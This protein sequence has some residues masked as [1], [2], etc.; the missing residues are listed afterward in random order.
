M[1]TYYI[2]LQVVVTL[3]SHWNW[4]DFVLHALKLFFISFSELDCILGIHLKMI[5]IVVDLRS[6]LFFGW[7]LSFGAINEAT[8]P[9]N[10]LLD[11]FLSIFLPS[12][13]ETRFSLIDHIV[14]WDRFWLSKGYYLISFNKRNL[15]S[16]KDIFD[17]NILIALQFIIL[18][19]LSEFLIFGLSS[20]LRFQ[21]LNKGHLLVSIGDIVG[22]ATLSFDGQLLMLDRDIVMLGMSYLN[23]STP[24][25]TLFFGGNPLAPEIVGNFF[26]RN[27]FHNI[28]EFYFFIKFDKVLGSFW[29]RRMS[30]N[31]RY[32][33]NFDINTQIILQFAI[34]L[35]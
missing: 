15:V 25:I 34:C 7:L 22:P 32:S 2:V 23:S 30:L 19:F 17:L 27:N 18:N 3:N 14:P 4:I 10:I 35:W 29:H 31:Y 26:L 11:V 28:F 33:S 24:R 8:V 12:E 16:I 1:L 9:E 21:F 5:E 6:Q 20:P 13:K